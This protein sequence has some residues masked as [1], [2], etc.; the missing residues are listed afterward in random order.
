[1]TKEQRQPSAAELIK[2]YIIKE[3]LD[4]D[5]APK[6]PASLPPEVIQSLLRLQECQR[7]CEL[8]REKDKRYGI[9]DTLK[10]VNNVVLDGK[11]KVKEPDEV[12]RSR[13]V[14]ANFPDPSMALSWTTPISE[15][16]YEQHLILIVVDDGGLTV[17]AG[18]RDKQN[19]FNFTRRVDF[20]DRFRED[21]NRAVAGAY[22]RSGYIQYAYEVP[23][24]GNYS[25]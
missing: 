16:S 15:H 14:Y 21:F 20:S 17:L 8:A 19:K 5:I 10:E 1:M 3:R 25:G 6:T 9:L 11:G 12:D 23:D 13:T 2:A 18:Q 4:T 7:Q 22:E 24:Y